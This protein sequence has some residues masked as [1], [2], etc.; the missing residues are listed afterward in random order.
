MKVSAREIPVIS[1]FGKDVRH[2]ICGSRI[3]A[4]IELRADGSKARGERDIIADVLIGIFNAY[5]HGPM[6]VGVIGDAELGC[7]GV[8]HSDAEVLILVVGNRKVRGHWPQAVAV[9]S[10]PTPR[11]SGKKLPFTSLQVHEIE[12]QTIGVG[13][14]A[15]IDTGGIV[16]AEIAF[17]I[18]GDI[19]A[20][21]IVR[22]F[23]AETRKLRRG[24][25]F[26]DVSQGRVVVGYGAEARR[27]IVLLVCGTK[28]IFEVDES[29]EGQYRVA[30]FEG[31]DRRL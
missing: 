1:D 3:G 24:S 12:A 14:H 8:R 22:H 30:K 25:K 4:V 23:N 13:I 21:E 9:G 11:L 29:P 6:F 16:S 7:P 19:V 31:P 15:L 10:Q 20:V 26:R 28:N 5:S 17:Y 27:D 2:E 18:A